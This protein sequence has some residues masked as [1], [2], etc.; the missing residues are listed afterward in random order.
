MIVD[1][2]TYGL[3]ALMALSLLRL[4]YTVA[5]CRGYSKAVAD[6]RERFL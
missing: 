1:Y 4:F 3:A 5:Y 2:I 6:V